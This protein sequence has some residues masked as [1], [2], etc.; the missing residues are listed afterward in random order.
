MLV[1]I[2]L[3][4]DEPVVAISKQNVFDAFAER[5]PNEPALTNEECVATFMRASREGLIE[6]ES[7]GGVRIVDGVRIDEREL[8]EAGA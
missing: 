8:G 5:F 7:V 1:F 4:G 2:D 3:L 6:I